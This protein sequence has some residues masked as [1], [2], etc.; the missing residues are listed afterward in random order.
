MEPRGGVLDMAQDVA[1]DIIGGGHGSGDDDK[2]VAEIIT[3]TV[4]ITQTTTTTSATTDTTTTTLTTTAEASTETVTSGTT[5]TATPYPYPYP[6]EQQVRSTATP[7]SEPQETPSAQENP[8]EGETTSTTETHTTSHHHHSASKTS[9][10]PGHHSTKSDEDDETPT[11]T[12]TDSGDSGAEESARP[13]GDSEP[14]DPP[15]D[16]SETSTSDS[17]FE[18]A[19]PRRKRMNRRDRHNV[20]LLNPRLVA[21]TLAVFGTATS[22]QTLRSPEVRAIAV[23]PEPTS[24]ALPEVLVPSS[25]VEKRENPSAPPSDIWVVSEDFGGYYGP[26][27]SSKVHAVRDCGIPCL[28]ETQTITT[29]VSVH[30]TPMAARDNTDTVSNVITA[31]DK[32]DPIATPYGTLNVP[33]TFSH[34]V[35]V[36][37]HADDH[38]PFGLPNFGNSSNTTFATSF[39]GTTGSAGFGLSCTGVFTSSM[40]NSNDS[41]IKHPDSIRRRWQGNRRWVARREAEL[42]M[43]EAAATTTVA[44][45]GEDKMPLRRGVES[46][47]APTSTLDE[48]DSFLALSKRAPGGLL[49]FLKKSTKGAKN[50]KATVTKTTAKPAATASSSPKTSSSSSVPKTMASGTAHHTASATSHHTT[51]ASSHATSHATVSHSTT[52]GLKDQLVALQPF[53]AAV[54][55]A[56]TANGVLPPSHPGQHPGVNGNTQGSSDT[57]GVPPSDGEAPQPPSGQEGP[58]EGGDPNGVTPNDVDAPQPP[59]GQQGSSEGDDN[60]TST[61]TSSQDPADGGEGNP[62]SNESTPSEH[63]QIPEHSS[64]GSGLQ[65]RAKPSNT[66]A[67]KE[68]PSFDARLLPDPNDKEQWRNDINGVLRPEGKAPPQSSGQ[69]SAGTATSSKSTSSIHAQATKHTSTSA[70]LHRRGKS[71]PRPATKGAAVA[72]PTESS[73]TSSQSSSSSTKTSSSS[74]SKTTPAATSGASGQGIQGALKTSTSVTHT[75]G[76]TAASSAGGQ[77]DKGGQKSSAVSSQASSPAA[78]APS[79]TQGGSDKSHPSGKSCPV[80]NMQIREIK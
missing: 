19:K 69:Q 10:K 63:E 8:P 35:P 40:T 7:D 64:A 79:G 74:I 62:T 72:L 48:S 67:A 57:N 50:G 66:P 23:S 6:P 16:R 49:G 32:R 30:A 36:R 28:D 75:P 53:A 25:A 4:E 3:T 51:A 39:V 14:E 46:S 55:S 76:H 21:S 59:S 45:N 15:A 73:M 77:E 70:K 1:G 71:T 20:P 44:A 58:G 11:T 29:S 65:R 26:S 47:F 54:H 43:Q 56:A 22:F 5:V 24:T 13:T 9:Q 17:G 33:N 41:S 42:D 2:T 12:S 68:L 37:R 78:P 60:S 18:K 80:P 38:A 27:Y 61:P 31:L 52:K 34:G